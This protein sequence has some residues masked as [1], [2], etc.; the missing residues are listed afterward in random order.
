MKKTLTEAFKA[1]PVGEILPLLTSRQYSLD[2][3]DAITTIAR[4]QSKRRM[5]N[6]EKT[7]GGA[8]AAYPM[9][10]GGN[11]GDREK[12]AVKFFSMFPATKRNLSTFNNLAFKRYLSGVKDIGKV[13]YKPLTMQEVTFLMDYSAVNDGGIDWR[14]AEINKNQHLIP[15]GKEPFKPTSQTHFNPI[16]SRGGGKAFEKFDEVKKSLKEQT[17]RKRELE[18]A[19]EKMRSKKSRY[20]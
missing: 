12:E 20:L 19:Q 13:L 5:S 4:S 15:F 2:Q 18:K 11:W 1:K 3:L 8:R 14:N 9:E 6:L 16:R 10:L 17:K 7:T